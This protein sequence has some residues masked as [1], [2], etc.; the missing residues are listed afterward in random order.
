MKN[1][2]F[3]YFC[4]INLC[5]CAN[6]VKQPIYKKVLNHKKYRK[7]TK[8]IYPMNLKIEFIVD[9]YRIFNSIDFGCRKES[10]S[11]ISIFMVLDMKQIH[12]LFVYL[13]RFHFL[14]NL[15]IG[16]G[17]LLLI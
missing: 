16:Q 3:S 15:H 10:I 14:L 12:F 11:R 1:Q 17:F 2:Y 4:I 8:D 7:L 5:C 6:D 9:I 13:L